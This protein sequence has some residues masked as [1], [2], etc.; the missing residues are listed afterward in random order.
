V[1]L[2]VFVA[3]SLADDRSALNPP[4]LALPDG[5]DEYAKF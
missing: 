3:M 1:N 2:D 5:I 4:P